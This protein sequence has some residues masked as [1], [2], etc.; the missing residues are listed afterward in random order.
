MLLKK[1]FLWAREAEPS[2]PLTA[3]VWIG[4]WPEGKPLAPIEALMLE[5]SDVV[6]F[7]NYGT[8]DEL[9][10]RVAGLRR[11][12]RPILCTEYMAR[13]RGSRF[14]PVLGYFKEEKVAA[15]NWGLVAG[16][17][18]TIYPWDSWSETLR[19]RARGLVPRHLSPRWDSVR[20]GRGGLHQESPRTVTSGSIRGSRGTLREYKSE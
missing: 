10:E 17:T 5:E 19:R 3:G 20:P 16:K 7:H 9:R 13:P 1:V 4:P 14:D 12:D 11:Y 15:Y 2:Q 6:S 8:L 18:Q